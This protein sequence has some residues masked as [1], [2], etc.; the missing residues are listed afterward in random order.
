MEAKV[1]SPPFRYVQTGNDSRSSCSPSKFTHT[2]THTHTHS[3][4]KSI[5]VLP[6]Y[7][8]L[9]FHVFASCDVIVSIFHNNVTCLLRNFY[10]LPI[11][12]ICINHRNNVISI[13][14]CRFVSCIYRISLLFPIAFTPCSNIDI[15]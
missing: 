5:F 4:I 3:F 15:L 8:C 13:R 2:H 6:Y 9:D 12:C 14:L 10:S 1:P 11:S 7:L